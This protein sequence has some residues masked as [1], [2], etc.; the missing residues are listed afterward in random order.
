MFLHTK[1]LDGEFCLCSS[2]PPSPFRLAWLG[3]AWL[4]LLERARY[5]HSRFQLFFTRKEKIIIERFLEFVCFLWTLYL[6]PFVIVLSWAGRV[7]IL[8]IREEGDGHNL[9]TSEVEHFF[10]IFFTHVARMPY[11]TFLFFLPPEALN[12]AART[13]LRPC[14]FPFFFRPKTPP[15]LCFPTSLRTELLLLALW[16]SKIAPDSFPP[17]FVAFFPVFFPLLIDDAGLRS[18]RFRS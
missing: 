15:G 1:I 12:A 10:L 9:Q 16:P 18:S 4:L 2:P 6:L 14:G 17:P 8:T 13:V 11:V 5:P 3:L 7:Y